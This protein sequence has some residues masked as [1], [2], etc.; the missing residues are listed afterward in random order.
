VAWL[1]GGAATG[2]GESPKPG[3]AAVSRARTTVIAGRM[4]A[5]RGAQREAERLGY[6]T[7]V[8][9]DPVVGE[10]RVAAAAHE[11]RVREALAGAAPACLLSAGETTVPVT[12]RGRGGRNQEFA[13]ASLRW[14]AGLGRPAVLASL[15]TDGI[16][17]PTDAAGALVDS[18]T[19]A[20]ALAG[21]TG[22]P[23]PALAGNDCYTYLDALGALVCTGPTGTNVGD[24]Q[25]VVTGAVSP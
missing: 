22:P 4:D 11:A 3:S 17:G 2:A 25:I 24:I 5:L 10:A 1:E 12:G 20:H 21:V 16:D 19:I 13:A 18:E 6:R 7:I 9:A 8:V 23:E 14:L 15:G